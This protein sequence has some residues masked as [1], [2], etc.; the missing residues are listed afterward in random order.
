MEHKSVSLE[1]KDF[2]AGSRT[3]VIAHAVYDNID[4]AGD[5]SRK[6]M[7]TKSWQEYKSI[8][9]FFNHDPKQ[10][11]GT[12]T[13]TFEDEQKAYTEVKFGNWQLGNDVMEM[14][15]AGVLRGASF[16][17]IA[18]KKNWIT[19]KGKR[20]RELKEVLHGETSLLT[21]LP[22]NPMAGIVSLTKSEQGAMMTELK[23]HIDAL[24]KF[25]RETKASDETIKKVLNDLA[26]AK[27]IMDKFDTG[28]TPTSVANGGEQLPSEEKADTSDDVLLKLKLLT[29]SM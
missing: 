27:A 26:E 28:D 14:A 3:A 10:I 29:L 5:I 1:L 21:E 16:G 13:R 23:A 18:Q 15:D 6:G 9:F 8:G 11:V 12:V 2:S 7:F 20:V 24:E 4:R 25:C 22:A 17:Y 19:V